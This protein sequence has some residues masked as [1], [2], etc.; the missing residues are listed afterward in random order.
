MKKIITIQLFLALILTSC[1]TPSKETPIESIT[2]EKGNIYY[3]VKGLEKPFK[4]LFAADCHITIEDE[5]GK[6]YCSYAKRM[7]GW[8]VESENY[9]KSNGREQALI[10]SLKKAKENG[11]EF[12][13]LGG[14]VINFPSQASVDLVLQIMNNSDI[15]WTF[16]SGNHDWHYEGEKG[17]S[18]ELRSKWHKESLLPLYQNK[19]SMYS[20]HILNSINFVS[21][22]NSLFEITKEQLLF[23]KDQI[24][25]KYPIIL[26]MHIP[27]YLPG[28]NI[29]YGYG[30]PN[31]NKSNDGYYE[32]E[33]REPWP[34]KGHNETIYA[35][36]YLVFNS[37]NVIGICAGHTHT[38]MLDFHNNI[39]QV[40][41]GENYNGED[42]TMHFI[43]CDKE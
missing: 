43:P 35:F 9:G 14:D 5:R 25:Q 19:N 24:K 37:S 15:P 22:D 18:A 42:I 8:T 34:E 31:W 30:S 36:R 27:L 4:V 12:V 29:D 13:I 11:V 7:G 28:H 33:R 26:S 39:P 38:E 17:T 6:P 23:F 32:I 10:T 2:V 40:V 41:A 20:S 16:I 21:I 3:Y 1:C